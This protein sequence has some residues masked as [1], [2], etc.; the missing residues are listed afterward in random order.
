MRAWTKIETEDMRKEDKGNKRIWRRN[1]KVR[2]EMWIQTK[3]GRK[4]NKG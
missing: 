4:K 3:I 2:M 1:E